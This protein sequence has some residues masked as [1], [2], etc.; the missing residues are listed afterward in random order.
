MWH[1]FTIPERLLRE[2]V[3][4]LKVNGILP[5]LDYAV[6]RN[7]ERAF[8]DKFC[9][10]LLTFPNNYHAIKLSA[11]DFDPETMGRI[12]RMASHTNNAIMVDAEEVRV[13]QRTDDIVDDISL[14]YDNVF[15]TYQM[16]RTDSLSTLERDMARFRSSGSVLN[17][18]LVRGAYLR[19]DRPT[20]MLYGTKEQTDQA[21][22]RAVDLLL[23]HEQDVGKVL[24]ATHNERSFEKFANAN[25]DKYFHGSLMGFEEP[26]RW[27]GSVAK[28]VYVPFGPYH[29]TYPYLLRRLYE[30]PFMVRRT[31]LES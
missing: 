8:E 6:E 13:Q 27:K 24:F 4:R 26:L 22:D 12:M 31:I 10:L 19:T 11:I 20:G 21:Y 28:M 3:L 9:N 2:K 29:K 15:K 30:N 14:R 25:G 7:M 18:K 16:Y 1:R 17:V 23:S 5:I